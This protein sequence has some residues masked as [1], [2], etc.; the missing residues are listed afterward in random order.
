MCDVFF[1]IVKLVEY[2]YF[3]QKLVSFFTYFFRFV[4]NHRAQVLVPFFLLV[5]G[6]KTRELLSVADSRLTKQAR[7][8]LF[9]CVSVVI[10]Q[11]R[12]Q[13]LLFSFQIVPCLII[14]QRFGGSSCETSYAVEMWVNAIKV[15]SVL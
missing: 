14:V 8:R 10:L 2:S 12:A 9:K 3:P 15:E 11:H 4:S 13:I 1:Q 7:H 6:V 5:V